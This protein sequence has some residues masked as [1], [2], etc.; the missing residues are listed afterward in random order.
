MGDSGWAYFEIDGDSTENEY[1]EALVGYMYDHLDYGS[2]AGEFS[3]QGEAI[4]NPE[5]RS[6]EGT[7]YYSEDSHDHITD[8]DIKI[9][10][11]KNFWFD[12]F[13]IECE[14][15]YD[16]ELNVAST[17][18]IKNGFLT[19]EHEDFCRNLDNKL[20]TQFSELFAKYQSAKGE[21]F[22]GCNDSWMFNKS[23]AIEEGDNLVFTINLIEV[24]TMDS[25]DKDIVLEI[26]DE[27]AEDIDYRLNKEHA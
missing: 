24:Q 16:D 25:Q 14:C 9:V 19:N 6:F 3:S 17:F 23:E 7:D 13:H 12:T 10:I 4:Y 11:P 8:L 20:I 21:E 18:N 1:T 2:W 22:R 26:T 5:T 27:M 15:H